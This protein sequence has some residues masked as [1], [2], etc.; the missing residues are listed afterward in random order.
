VSSEVTDASRELERLRGR[1]TALE[2]E[3][4]EVKAWANR[5]VAEAQAR[6]YWLDRWNVDLNEV[7]RRRSAQR[8]RALVRAVRSVVRRLRQL[9]WRY[10]R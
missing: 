10:L 9:K 2:E 7:M 5:E 1:V 4:I 3:L 6:T 8:A